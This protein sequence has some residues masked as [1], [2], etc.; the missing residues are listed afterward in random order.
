[1]RDTGY[2]FVTIE[3]KSFDLVSEGREMKG[4]RISEIGRGFRVSISLEEEVE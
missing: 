1:M 3:G 4:L 2:K